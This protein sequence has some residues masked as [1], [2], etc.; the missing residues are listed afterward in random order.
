[1][2]LVISYGRSIVWT[3]GYG[4]YDIV[5]ISVRRKKYYAV[6]GL[7]HH[8]LIILYSDDLKAPI[9]MAHCGHSFCNECLIAYVRGAGRWECPKCRRI[10]N[11]TVEELPRNFDLENIVESLSNVQIQPNT[12]FGFCDRHQTPIKLRKFNV[13]KFM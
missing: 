3:I 11:S 8:S 12:E 10:T 4:Q 6:K 2:N 7:L 5:D 9:K 1:M 13:L